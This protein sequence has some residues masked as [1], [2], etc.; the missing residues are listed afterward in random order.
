VLILTSAF[1]SWHGLVAHRMPDLR[2]RLAEEHPEV[3]VWAGGGIVLREQPAGREVL[4]IHRPHRDDWSFPKGKLDEG[5]TLGQTAERE[6]EEET[7]FR[8]RR[9]DRLAPVRYTDNRGREKLV[10]Y[11][12]MVAESGE[13]APNDEVDTLGWFTVTAARGV[14]SYER[15]IELLDAIH[16]SEPELRLQA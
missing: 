8:C 11:W 7:G 12:T 13:F 14:L 9:I 2:A 16:P 1:N 6:V 3:T 15:D 4:I 10:V 5:E